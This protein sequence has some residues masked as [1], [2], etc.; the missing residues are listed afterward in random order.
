MAV[1]LTRIVSS[2]FSLRSFLPPRPFLRHVES[3]RINRKLLVFDSSSIAPLSSRLNE[4]L[5]SM[6]ERKAFARVTYHLRRQIV[7]RF[8]TS[9]DGIQRRD[10][11]VFD[12]MKIFFASLTEFDVFDG[13]EHRF[14]QIEMRVILEGR[15]DCTQ[16]KNS[17]T[18]STSV[19][20]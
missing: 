1:I 5:G 4:W 11:R 20:V 16:E 2:R 9:F 6:K 14:A 3:S 18:F 10:D 7:R 19:R 15:I 12:G 17:P 8:G 13:G